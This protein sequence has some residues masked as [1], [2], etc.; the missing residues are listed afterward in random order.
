TNCHLSFF[1]GHLSFRCFIPR[2]L[3]LRLSCSVFI[4]VHLWFRKRRLS[5][6]GPG[7]WFILPFVNIPAQ[8]EP[9][10]GQVRHAHLAFLKPERG[11]VEQITRAPVLFGEEKVWDAT[12]QHELHVQAK[13]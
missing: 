2:A 9:A 12:R 13:E 11:S 6:H 5:H 7:G 8:N 4:G 3:W 10:S 1:I